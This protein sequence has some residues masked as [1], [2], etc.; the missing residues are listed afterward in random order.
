MI[1][2]VV[3]AVAIY[4][5]AIV[6]ASSY[7][8]VMNGSNAMVAPAPAPH[9]EQA[10]TLTVAA[11]GR[12]NVRINSSPTDIAVS[13]GSTGSA[14][15]TVGT[16]ITLTASDGRDVVWSGACSSNGSKRK[17][18]VFTLNTN[19]SVTANVQ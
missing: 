3:A 12:S 18:C 15:F 9:D 10:A 8:S 14:S 19:A 2:L 7:L 16:P 13:T 17:T 5:G 6:S 11:T 1:R 4:L